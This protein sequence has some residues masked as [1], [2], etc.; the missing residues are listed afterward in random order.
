MKL[1]SSSAV[2]SLTVN[3]VVGGSNPPSSANV[4]RFPSP[5]LRGGDTSPSRLS[6]AL[7]DIACAIAWFCLGCLGLLGCLFAV[8]ALVFEIIAAFH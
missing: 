5:K 4:L 2:E 7:I 6:Q 3:Q 1:E 8:G